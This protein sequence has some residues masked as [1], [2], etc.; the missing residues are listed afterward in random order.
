MSYTEHEHIREWMTEHESY[1]LDQ[2]Y[3]QS[4]HQYLESLPWNPSRIDWSEVPHTFIS[5][6]EGEDEVVSRLSGMPIGRH[7]Y[8]MVNYHDSDN[9]I[10][11]RAED[12]FRDA[13]VL[14]MRSPGPRYMCGAD[15]EG[16]TTVLAVKDFAECDL[17]GFTARV[18]EK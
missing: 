7:S 8:V 12:A 18:N 9:S 2:R 17:P 14:Y 4:F 15:V 5:M 6:E 3:S 13:G 11:C 10:L 16:N 1:V